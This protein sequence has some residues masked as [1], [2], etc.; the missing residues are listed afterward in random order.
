MT[1]VELTAL[2]V[3]RALGL[4]INTVHRHIKAKRFPGARLADDARS[5][6][7]VIPARD[8]LEHARKGKAGQ[9]A[10]AERVIE[11]VRR[12]QEEELAE[13]D[14]CGEFSLAI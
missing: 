6:G 8:V 3:S 2:E 5:Q 9:V 10:K 1:D 7:W 13:L 14:D 4:H 12:K 11:Q